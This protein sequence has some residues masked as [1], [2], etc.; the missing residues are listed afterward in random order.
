[1]ERY[2]QY[3][4]EEFIQ[5]ASFQ[6]WVLRPTPESEAFWK[7]WLERHPHQGEE[8]REAAAF[9]RSLQFKAF[10]PGPAEIEQSWERHWQHIQ[11]G[12]R[13]RLAGARHRRRYGWAAAA[14]VAVALV[15]W[16]AF[17]R[18]GQL[19][20][21]RLATGTGENRTVVLPDSTVIILNQ[22]SGLHYSRHWDLA[23]R[24]EV[25]LNGEAFFNVRQN[26]AGTKPFVVHTA[27]LD[28]EV[29]GTQFNVK[30]AAGF[31]NVSLNRGRIRVNLTDTAQKPVYLKPGELLRYTP[32]DHRLTKKQILPELYASWKE[33]KISLDK[34]PLLQIAQMIEDI[35]GDSVRITSP[36][37]AKSAISGTLQVRDEDALLE[38]LAF[39]LNIEIR[40]E[41]HLLIFT[42]RLLS[43]P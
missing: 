26:G 43:T 24:R 20:D 30:N 32:S 9:I 25:W 29:L 36:V 18:P 42:P 31:T 21:I 17:G 8:I 11:S 7:A 12:T 19:Q 33:E 14:V 41:P 4:R 2:D 3:G 5:D 13:R 23:Q 37:L 40:K 34:V 10:L 35:Y 39:A 38:T 15:G 16:W 6:Q 1:M 22:R 28:V 27:G